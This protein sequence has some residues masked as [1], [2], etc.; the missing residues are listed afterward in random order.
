MAALLPAS[1]VALAFPGIQW[2]PMQKLRLTS[3]E[4][5]ILRSAEANPIDYTLCDAEQSMTY[6][7][8]LLKVL[9]EASGAS[10]PSSKVSRQKESLNEE[11]ALGMLYTD[12]MG[13]V[14]HYAITKLYDVVQCLREKK[15]SSGVSLGSTF[16]NEDGNLIDEWRP[17]LRVLHLGGGGDA[18]AQRG[19]AYCLTFILMAG[20]ASQRYTTNPLQKMNHSSVKEPLAALI[21]WITSQLQSSASSSLS[22]VTPTLTALMSCPEARILF[23]D[24]GGIGYL[25]RHIRNGCRGTKQRVSGGTA[26]VQQLYELCFCLWTLTYECN[27][28]SSIRATFARDNAVNSLVDLVSTAPREKVVRVA[29]SALRTL[30]CCTGNFTVSSGDSSS[31]KEITSAT[32]L[33]E[34]IGCGLIKYIDQMKERQWTDP[35]IVDDLETLHKLL[36]ANFKEMTTWDVYLAE[37]QNGSLEWGILHTEKFF[38]ENARRFEGTNGDFSVV[39]ILIALTA[40]HDEEVQSIACY[41]IGE[42]VRHYP[43]GRTIARTL[44]A[45]DI[46]LKL[47][48][49]SNEELSRQALT[50]VSKMMVQN[51]QDNNM[52]MFIRESC[53]IHINS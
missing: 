34:M 40:S 47:V 15:I 48:D 11:D 9:A 52:N 14:T 10:G 13:V 53:N 36:H 7:K 1:P 4:K 32:F 18:F 22:L 45:K 5:H 3:P 19:A 43:N 37:V 20:C 17:L 33:N 41:D 49:H 39:K 24:S 51:W 30:A 42:F 50:C 25:S 31:R 16:Y 38:K 12:P 6:A 8:A 23:A 21:S 27:N 29:L 28:S 26:S 35:D 46:V 2:D 44:G